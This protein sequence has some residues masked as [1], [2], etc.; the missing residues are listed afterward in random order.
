V[1]NHIRHL[2]HKLDCHSQL[3]AVAVAYRLN[4][5]RPPGVGTS[6]A[7]LRGG[8]RDGPGG[9]GAAGP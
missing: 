7:R 3:E 5:L 9:D 4:L 6:A 1:R 8:A 2:L